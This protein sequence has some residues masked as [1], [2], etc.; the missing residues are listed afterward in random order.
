MASSSA[1]GIYM[2]DIPSPYARRWPRLNGYCRPDSLHTLTTAYPLEQ[3]NEALAALRE[4]R[5]AG[6]AVLTIHP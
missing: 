5:L 3:A 4:G 2:S 1:V 6:A